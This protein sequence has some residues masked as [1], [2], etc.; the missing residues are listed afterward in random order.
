MVVR[1]YQW[2]EPWQQG[3]EDAKDSLFPDLEGASRLRGGGLAG[4]LPNDFLLGAGS[5][6]GETVV[7]RIR[8]NDYV[9]LGSPYMEQPPPPG[10]YTRWRDFCR[11]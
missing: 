1:Y 11:L 2:T 3:L 9:D 7:M 8:T 4:G 5:V 10:H 6:L